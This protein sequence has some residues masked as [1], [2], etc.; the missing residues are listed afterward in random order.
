MYP[1]VRTHHLVLGAVSIALVALLAVHPELLGS[2]LADAF[3]GVTTANPVWLWAA[4]AAFAI[5]HVVGGLAWRSA[6]GACGTPTRRG[7]AVARY[8]VGSGVNAVAP[9]HLGSA[10]RIALFARV[11][12]GDGGVWRVGGVGAAVGAV[13]GVWLAAVVAAAAATGAVPM[14]PIVALAVALAIACAVALGS[15]RLRL[16]HG[17]KVAHVLDAFHELGRAPRPLLTV[18]ALAAA[19]MALKLSAAAAVAMA[20]DVNHP[21]LAALVL[22]P[23]VELAAVMPVTPGNTGIASAAAA[24]ALGA[25][26]VDGETAMSAGIAFGAV[27]TLA[28]VAVGAAAALALSKAKMRP[29]LRLGVAAAGSSAVASACALTVIGPLL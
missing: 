16:R 23:A 22:V 13:R 7:D 25:T 19:G 20:L 5:T 26:G 2:R 6:L 29:A 17:R 18:A 28:A 10:V 11:V 27:E 1:F 21:L 12:E 14:W 24:L 8:G 15:R 3:H 9:A 4:G